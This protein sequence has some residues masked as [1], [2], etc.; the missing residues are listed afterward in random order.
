[1]KNACQLGEH[2]FVLMGM[3][4]NASGIDET[5]GWA[6]QDSPGKVNWRQIID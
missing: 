5:S 3:G 6:R 2:F 4:S 1:M